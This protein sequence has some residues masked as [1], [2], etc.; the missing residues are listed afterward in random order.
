MVEKFEWVE[1]PIRVTLEYAGFR[2][3]RDYFEYELWDN[4]ELIFDLADY[5]TGPG[6]ADDGEEMVY[7]L[8]H[9]LTLQP[10]DTDDEYFDSWTERQIEWVGG[11][12][13]DNLR[14]LI[15]NERDR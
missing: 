9:F 10:G 14:R 12:S 2:D 6:G 11:E 13:A 1:G 3:G 5:S 7:S 4:G 15:Y 8:L